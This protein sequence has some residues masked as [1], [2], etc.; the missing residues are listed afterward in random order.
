MEWM[1]F[2]TTSSWHWQGK[3][4]LVKELNSFD[5]F[6]SWPLV[7]EELAAGYP[8]SSWLRFELGPLKSILVYFLSDLTS[9]QIILFHAKGGHAE[10]FPVQGKEICVSPFLLAWHW[11]GYSGK[12]RS[13]C[14]EGWFLFILF[15]C[16]CNLSVKL[17]ALRCTALHLIMTKRLRA[18]A[19]TTLI[20]VCWYFSLTTEALLIFPLCREPP[21]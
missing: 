4:L 3:F 21:G 19:Q 16:V 11:E 17:S 2:P 12:Q 5:S 20:P 14:N 1:A 9:L 6:R 13:F 10:N 7:M 18:Q 8:E 15:V